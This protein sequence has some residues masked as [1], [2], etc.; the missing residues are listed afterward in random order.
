MKNSEFY[1]RITGSVRGCLDRVEIMREL[2]TG[3]EQ[4][5]QSDKYSPAYRQIF[6]DNARDK[7]IEI[8]EALDECRRECRAVCEEYANFLRDE[9]ALKGADVNDDMRLLQ[10]GIRLST[11]DVKSMIQRNAGNRTMLQLI[12]NYAEDHG[13]ETG[14]RYIGNKRKVD[15]VMSAMSAVE[16]TLKWWEDPKVGMFDKLMGEGS[17]LHGQFSED[18]EAPETPVTFNGATFTQEQANAIIDALKG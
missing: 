13:I 9:D 2:M 14:L 7:R 5:A 4:N 1:K 8:R 18:D 16:V 10:D 17:I 3:M 11:Q 15:E 12:L 6:S